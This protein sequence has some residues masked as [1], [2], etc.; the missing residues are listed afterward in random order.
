VGRP[1]AGV[2]ALVDR[3]ALGDD[4]YNGQFCGAVAVGARTFLTAAH[5]VSGR[6]PSS[7]DVIAMADSLCFGTWINGQRLQVR[8]IEV[9]ARYDPASLRFD[10][11]TLTVAEDVIGPTRVTGR[12]EGAASRAFAFGWGVP[13][14]GAATACRLQA[15][16]L[17]VPGQ[18][19]CGGLVG[20]GE[21]AFDP[22]SMVCA[23]PAYSTA[24]TCAGDSGGPLIVGSEPDSGTVVGIVS[25]GRGCGVGWAGAYARTIVASD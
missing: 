19:A 11:A 21:R 4:P 15:V 13:S 6:R 5:C 25:W 8:G 14:P 2:A 20:S 9:D 18:E 3:D 23:V 17:R 12:L 24:D 10:I 22:A 1:V 16:E 7:L